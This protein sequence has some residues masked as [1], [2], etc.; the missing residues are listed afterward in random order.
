MAREIIFE[1][2]DVALEATRGTAVTPPTHRLYMEGMLTPE[3]DWFD[4]ET[5]VGTAAGL[6]RSEKL[7]TRTTLTAEGAMDVNTL[8]VIGNMALAPVTSP[9]TPS[10][11]TNARLWTFTRNVTSD[12]VESGTFYSTDP[13]DISYQAAFGM[14]TELRLN[15]DASGTDGAMQGF[16]AIGQT[17][18]PLGAVPTLP[19]NALAPLIVGARMQ[20]WVDTSSAIGTTEITGR[21]V[22]ADAT[23]PTIVGNP[24]YVAV[25]PS[26][27]IT[28]ARFGKRKTV[29]ELVVQV[30]KIDE[31]QLDNYLDTDDVKV[32]VRWNGPLIE[33]GFYNYVELD[34]YGKFRFDSWGD[35]EG[36]RTLSLLLR[37]EY[38]STAGTDVIMRVQNDNTTL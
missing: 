3:D 24:K 18:T 31:T 37:G 38:N 6:N 22:S 36:N 34:M 7:H 19:T 28:F 16:D 9:T 32:R 11:A 29:P 26:A 20:L 35:L 1:R 12:T 27:A 33:V 15:A 17:L 14:V 4:D 13:N 30:D 25:G 21:V 23:I 5:N 2:L 10:G 8:P